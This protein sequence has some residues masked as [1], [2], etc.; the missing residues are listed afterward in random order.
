MGARR[1]L[2]R[3]AQIRRPGASVPQRGP[4]TEL[5][6]PGKPTNVLKIIHK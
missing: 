3:G 4:G 1:I 6:G 5:M 2:S